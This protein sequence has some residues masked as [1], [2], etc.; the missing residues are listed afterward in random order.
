MSG[1]RVAE[2][3]GF[4]L[5]YVCTGNICRSP[6]AEILTRHLLIGRLGGRA[7]ARFDVGSAGVE[8]VVGHGVHP[9]TRAELAPWGL[10]RTAADRFT[11]RR[12]SPAMVDEA[13]LVLGASPRHRSSVVERNPAGLSRTFA[14]RE[15]ARLAAAVDPAELPDEPVARAHALV[16]AARAR[17]G[18]LPPVPP[19]EERVPDPI[20]GG[21]DEH[22]AAAVL[23]RDAV[24]TVV[25]AVAPPAPGVGPVRPAP[26]PVPA[27]GLPPRVRR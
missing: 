21:P 24:T 19:D 23:L 7:A 9:L 26:V 5:L 3:S 4:R 25:D 22:H 8:A 20:R 2:E 18:L 14:V 13:D 1:E 10:D 12:L 11:A 15:F 17:R 27:G 16:V 6:F